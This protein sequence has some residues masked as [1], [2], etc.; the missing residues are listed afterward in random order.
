MEAILAGK[1]P[2]FLDIA[3]NLLAENKKFLVGYS[4][5][6]NILRDRDRPT[7]REKH[8]YRERGR[9]TYREI[10]TERRTE[11]VTDRR[12]DREKHGDRERGR[13]TYREIVTERQ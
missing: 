11:T 12:T 10:V 7:D 4:V 6:Y 13:Q 5:S 1:L 9:Q 3:E 8:G 2:I